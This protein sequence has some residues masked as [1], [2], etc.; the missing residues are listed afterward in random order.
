MASIFSRTPPPRRLSLDEI[1]APELTHLKKGSS[2]RHTTARSKTT[3]W[4]LT[5][6]ICALLGLYF[7]DP[8]LYAMHKS[9][10]IRAYL[11]LHQNDSPSSTQALADSQILSQDEIAALNQ[12]QGNYQ[13]YFSS[14]QDAEEQAAA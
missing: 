3:P 11:Y 4:I 13:D 5:I 14:S 6:A 12:R 2:V 10:A 8:F 9:E 7:M 1:L